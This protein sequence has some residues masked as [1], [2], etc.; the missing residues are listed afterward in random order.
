VLITGAAGGVG[1]LAVQIAAH[2]GAQVTAVVGHPGRA[3]GL[4]ECG[5]HD[6]VHG[7]ENATGRYALILESAG[8]TS[9]SEAVRRIEPNG[10]VVVYGNSSGEASTISF[11]DFRAAQNA[12]IQSFFYFTSGPEELF[13]PDLGLLVSLVADGSL[14]PVIGIERDWS[15]LATVAE[16]LRTRQ[17]TGK[18]V[19]RTGES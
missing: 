2:S 17:V 6:V 11:Q 19:F 1:S 13:A 14:R 10:T 5:A 15:E 7:I 16:L 9:L 18:A 3:E 12:R 8:G 4:I